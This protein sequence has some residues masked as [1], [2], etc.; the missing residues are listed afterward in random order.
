MNLRKFNIGTRLGLGFG[1]ILCAALVIVF[2]SI[3]SAAF[4]RNAM[5]KTIQDTGFHQEQAVA[6]RH[7]LM[8]SAVAARN[9]GQIGRA[10]V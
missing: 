7:A 6:M 10:H 3:A 2:A 8:S 9:M 1:L 5:M 4:N